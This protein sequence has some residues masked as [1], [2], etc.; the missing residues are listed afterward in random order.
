[1]KKRILFP[2]L[3]IFTLLG[4]ILFN[5]FVSSKFKSGS[6][7]SKQ[8]KL[9]VPMMLPKVVKTKEKFYVLSQG[10][11][12]GFRRQLNISVNALPADTQ[13]V[14]YE[15]LPLNAI[16][17]KITDAG[18][19]RSF[20]GA[21]VIENKLFIAGG[22]DSKW[23]PASN[24]FEYDFISKKWTSKKS[25]NISRVNFA[26]ECING[27]IYAIGGENTNGSVEIY[28]PENNQW[29]LIKVNFLPNKLE[30]LKSITSSSVIENKIFLLGKQ[31]SAFKIFA[32]ET[33]IMTEGPVA[34]FSTMYFCSAVSNK[35]IY[36]AGGINK[37]E[38]DPCVYLFNMVDG[39][40]TNVGKIPVPR[41]GSGLL[42]YNSML[43]FLGGSISNP[44]QPATPTNE[45]YIYRPVK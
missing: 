42:Y 7:Y 44:S 13:I 9:S 6:T 16:L 39:S 8:A 22:F 31:N 14:I 12:E 21:C 30:P 41:Y 3:I 40:W 1:M 26:L 17:K 10:N 38:F 20:F 33:G 4:I 34:P 45:I 25:M 43:L 32:P 11:S 18:F 27:K 19:V 36:I 29:E 15:F 35:K 28:Q 5:S 2:T 37:N 24:L 23:N